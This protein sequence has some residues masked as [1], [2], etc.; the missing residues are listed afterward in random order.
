MEKQIFFRLKKLLAFDYEILHQIALSPGLF[1]S[2]LQLVLEHLPLL[3][4][5]SLEAVYSFIPKNA[6]T[7][8]RFSI[9]VSNGFLK[10]ISDLHWIHENN[11]T[12]QP[13]KRETAIAK[14]TFVV[15]NEC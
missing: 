10:E 6:C 15:Q 7:S 2:L 5:Y 12:F 14:Y 8:L 11:D 13:S 9:A 4:I 1:L 3:L